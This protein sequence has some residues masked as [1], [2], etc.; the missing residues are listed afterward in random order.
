LVLVSGLLTTGAT[1]AA[2]VAEPIDTS[3]IFVKKA[4]A[5]TMNTHPAV[6]RRRGQRDT[7]PGECRENQPVAWSD[8]GARCASV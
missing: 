4:I 5:D 3:G 8:R 2:A 7:A 6:P 1:G